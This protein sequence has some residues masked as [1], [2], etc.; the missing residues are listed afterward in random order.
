[1]LIGFQNT[2]VISPQGK[3]WSSSPAKI[4]YLGPYG[5]TASRAEYNRL[6]GEWLAAGRVV[7][8][9]EAQLTIT[10]LCVRYL[11][12]AKRYYQQNGAP[13]RSLERVKT[14]IRVLRKPYAY[15]LIGDFGPLA[16]QALQQKLATSRLSRVY[17]NYLI[18]TI[19]RM[20]K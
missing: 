15:T 3:P 1:M 14:S 16:L 18:D 13:T 2:V 4:C 19:R 7:P 5:A 10:E 6:I 11:N 17:V 8:K 9:P 12:F 20:F